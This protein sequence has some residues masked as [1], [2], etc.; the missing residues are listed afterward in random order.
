MT[1]GEEILWLESGARIDTP[2]SGTL[3]WL[4]QR[5]GN[6]GVSLQRISRTIDRERSGF[7]DEFPLVKGVAPPFALKLVA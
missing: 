1:P 5:T 2:L 4:G 3:C 6:L 7:E